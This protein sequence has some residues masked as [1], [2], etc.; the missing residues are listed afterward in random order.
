MVDTKF[1]GLQIDNH[2][3]LKNHIEQMLH[4]LSGTYYAIRSMVHISNIN[5]LK[6]VYY[7]YIRSIIKYGIIFWGNFSNSGKIFTLKKK[8]VRIM[9]GAQ[10]RT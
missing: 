4:K 2:V 3:N 7:T 9:N 5:T 6:S 8:T 10:H 1:L